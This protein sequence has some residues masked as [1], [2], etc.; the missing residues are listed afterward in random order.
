MKLVYGNLASL[1][2]YTILLLLGAIFTESEML[3]IISFINI[4][5]LLY[6]YNKIKSKEI[7]NT[8]EKN[9]INKINL[10]E[11]KQIAEDTVNRKYENINL[12]NKEKEKL[13]REEYI[14]LMIERGKK[15]FY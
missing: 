11:L 2:I 7:K 8:K 4:I 9:V 3:F 13:I 14:R 5:L 10:K 6:Q 12:E 1:T 15:W